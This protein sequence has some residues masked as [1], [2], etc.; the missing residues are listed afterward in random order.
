ML[1]LLSTIGTILF[2]VIGYSWLAVVMVSEVNKSS[3][4]NRRPHKG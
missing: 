1:N 2:M 3:K 4:S